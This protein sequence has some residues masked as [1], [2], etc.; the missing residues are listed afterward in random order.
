MSDSYPFPMYSGLLEPRHYKKIGSAIWLFLWCVSSTTAER[1]RD[2]VVWGIVLGNKPVQLSEL[3]EIFGVSSKTVSRWL[4]DLES[5]QYIKVT[6]APRGL[7]ISVRNSK[8]YRNQTPDKNVRSLRS[9]ETEMSTHGPSDQTKVSD[10]AD[11]NVRSNKDITEINNDVDDVDKEQE[12][13]M[14]LRSYCEIHQKLDIHV[15][16][17]DITLMHE[18]IALGVPSPLIIRVMGQVHRD[19]TARGERISS[20]A[21]YKNAILDA[22]EAERAITE[23]VPIPPV[24]LGSPRRRTKQQRDLEELE[25]LREE[26]IR[27]EQSGSH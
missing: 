5:H 2:G 12:F 7:I 27:R 10:Q 25:K 1:D 3:G 14:I 17:L 18:M 8:K 9:D 22:W 16:P 15:R 19:K 11:K 21:Y 26:A 24:A 6:R 20:F 23:G 4:T 13:E